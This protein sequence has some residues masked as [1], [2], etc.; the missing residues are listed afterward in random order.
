MQPSQPG[1]SGVKLTPS[2]SGMTGLDAGTLSAIS[3]WASLPLTASN[4]TQNQT[5]DNLRLRLNAQA[6]VQEANTPPVS[7]GELGETRFASGIFSLIL[8]KL[9]VDGVLYAKSRR[10]TNQE[11]TMEGD[12]S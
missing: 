11:P 10:R 5:T 1:V 9:G 7:P 3:L 6:A 4:R 8:G 2:Y 12:Q